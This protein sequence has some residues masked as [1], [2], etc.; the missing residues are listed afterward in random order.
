MADMKKTKERTAKKQK[1]E[2]DWAELA[3]PYDYANRSHCR[4]VR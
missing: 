3:K 1:P 2:P 4:R